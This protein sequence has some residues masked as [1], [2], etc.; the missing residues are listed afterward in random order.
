MTGQYGAAAVLFCE[1]SVERGIGVTV[2]RWGEPA[3]R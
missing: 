1:S 3:F 2:P